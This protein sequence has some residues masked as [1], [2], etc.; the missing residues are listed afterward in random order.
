MSVEMGKRLFAQHTSIVTDHDHPVVDVGG[1]V[2]NLVLFERLILESAC[3]AEFPVLLRVFGMEG[4]MKLLSSGA[5]DIQCE[6]VVVG[7]VGQS[8][9]QV[10][11]PLP[12]FS[13]GFALLRGTGDYI[14]QCMAKLKWGEPSLQGTSLKCKRPLRID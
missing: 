2:L 7:Q 14:H 13:Y 8:S 9:L 12:H 10:P 1:F 11:G 6:A 3:L 4:L 5:V